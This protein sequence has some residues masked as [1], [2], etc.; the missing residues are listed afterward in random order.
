MKRCGIKVKGIVQGVG[1]R[2][3]VYRLANDLN[4]KGF[5]RNTT[6]GVDIEVEG[7]RQSIAKFIERLQFEKPRAARI[8]RFVTKDLAPNGNKRFVIKKSRISKGFT[9]ISADIATCDDCLCEL[10]EVDDRRYNYPFI[11]CTNCGPRY[12]IILDTPYDRKRTSMKKFKMCHDCEREFNDVSDRRFHAQPDCCAVCGPSFILYSMNGREV[13]ATDPISKTAELLKKGKI[14]AIKGIGGFHIAC[15]ATNKK[16]I[17]QLRKF[18][19]RPTKPFAVMM[20][21]RDLSKVV[22]HKTKEKEIMKSPVAPIMLL[23]KKGKIICEEVAPNNP[24]LGVMAPYAPIHHLLLEEIPYL[25]MTSANIQD[26]PIVTDEIDVIRKLNTM[27]SHYLTHDRKIENRCDDSVGFYSPNKG[28]SILR[29]SRG[30]VPAP[31]NLPAAVKPTLAVGPYLK[32]TFT[33]ANKKEAYVSPHIGDLDNLETLEFFNEMVDKYQRWFRVEPQLIVHDIHPDYLSTKIAQKMSGEKIGVQHHIAHVVS[34]L[35]ENM[36]FDDT[37]GIAFD[38]TGFGTD[39]RIWGGEFFV[40]NMNVQKR[41]AHLDYLPLP[42]GEVSIRKPYRITTAYIYKLL[43]EKF[44]PK[45]VSSE[46]INAIVRM[47]RQDRNVI[48]TSSMGRF[49]DC[50][51]AMLGLINEITYEAEAAINLEYIAA[52]GIR[53]GYSYK[54]RSEDLLIVEL[55][56]I[57]EGVLIDVK[58]GVPRD[59][60]S[61]K[62][63]NTVA[64]FSL[65]VAERL[66]RLYKMKSACFSGGVFQNQYLL[67]L[68]IRTFEDAGF[69]VYVHRKLPT[70]DGCISYGQVIYGNL[71]NGK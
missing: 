54:I 59:I 9:Q 18:K 45:N 4:L 67:D 24:Y 7:K 51:A 55:S 43:G 70:N 5:V 28:F 47:I 60:I 19:K 36:V 23:K 31:M 32:N 25:V 38:G 71:I 68:M 44:R 20:R 48:Y 56:E 2:P 34:C 61:A 10:K 65:D 62:F 46:E 53:Q 3:F 26:E 30:Y 39:G 52:K 14:V 21:S 41:V 33:L 40:G 69:R 12:S 35:G 29:R 6:E 11:N 16:V 13:M 17:R 8:E 66:S 1:F 15:D 27:V 50:V 58:K 64:Y 42:G 37:I 22:Y 57:L 49:F 63:H